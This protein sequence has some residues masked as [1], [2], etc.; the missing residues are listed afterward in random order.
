MVD[1][2][3]TRATIEV[4]DRGMLWD[5]KIGDA[6]ITLPSVPSDKDQVVVGPQWAELDG[7]TG[8]VAY[9]LRVADSKKAFTGNNLESSS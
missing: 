2:S 6:I 5:T 3:V 8:R 1:E 7:D 9:S 4:Y